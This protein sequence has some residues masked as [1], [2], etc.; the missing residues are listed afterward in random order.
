[1]AFT[2]HQLPVFEA[3]FVSITVVGN[4]SL[5]HY[6][7]NLEVTLYFFHYHFSLH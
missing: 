5:R 4:V 7:F 3:K 2:F 1:M 6:T